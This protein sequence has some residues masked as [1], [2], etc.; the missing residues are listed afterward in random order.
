LPESR[1]FA[2][3]SFYKKTVLKENQIG[4]EIISMAVGPL[5]ANSY[6]IFDR[7][8]SAGF[9][10]DPGGNPEVI[11]AAIN[12]AGTGCQA[13]FITHGHQ[14]HIGGVAGLAAETGAE[15]YASAEVE[16]VL[17][18]PANFSLFPG[19]PAI[20]SYK[21]DKVLDGGEK[22]DVKGV[23][24]LALATPGH[25][26]GSLTYYA[27]NSLFTGDLLFHGSIGRT[28][29]PGGSFDDLAASVKNL[30]LRFPPDT[31]VYPG[32]GNSTTLETER[33]KNP[34]L[35]DLGW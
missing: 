23:E 35:T 2:S 24:V 18:E 20:S 34:F 26:R 5:Q 17:A 9:V 4:I 25:S 19:M 12:E 27:A 16:T 1:L 3:V 31:K 33:E 15:V 30:I 22:I 29:L 32:H 13:I 10:V 6:L 14:D 28:D 7:E 21:V 8:V 11:N